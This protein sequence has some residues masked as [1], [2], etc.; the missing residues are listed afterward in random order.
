KWLLEELRVS[1]FAQE[2]GTREKVSVKRLDTLWRRL[3]A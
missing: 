1:M 2:L 3:D